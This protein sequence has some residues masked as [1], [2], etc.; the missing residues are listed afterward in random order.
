M[1]SNLDQLIQSAKAGDPVAQ[2]Q[3]GFHGKDSYQNY[4]WYKLSA[5]QGYIPAVYML[6]LCYQG[7]KGVEKD[8][9]EAIKCF[10][11]A[12]MGGEIAGGLSN[13]MAHYM[14]GE[15]P[16]IYQ[17]QCLK[18]FLKYAHIDWVAYNIGD[19][20]MNGIGVEQNYVEGAEWYRK[21]AKQGS[22]IG[23][24]RLAQCY[25]MGK[26]VESSIAKAYRYYD[27]AA[28]KGVKPAKIKLGYAFESSPDIS[29]LSLLELRTRGDDYFY[30]RDG[31][32]QN[33]KIA[34]KY[35]YF[36][37]EKGS[38]IGINSLGNCYYHGN[39]CPVNHS[40]AIQYFKQA[41]QKGY[42]YAQYNLA[43]MYEHG[44]GTEKDLTKAAS[45]YRQAADQGHL[46]ASKRLEHLQL[47]I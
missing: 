35:Y 15:V 26:G 21:A 2:Y 1:E 20:Y 7:G 8:I 39:G 41:A 3:L 42:L 6:G 4:K 47:V 31:V 12:A 29:R 46:Q 33:Y 40:L 13:L 32:S 25:E 34:L 5:E 37:A 16:A 36:A 23:L 45:L 14:D 17:D 43:W 30:G 9:I 28:E 10:Y 11:Q 22:G 38:I 27:L 18:C 44:E 19:I 24:Y